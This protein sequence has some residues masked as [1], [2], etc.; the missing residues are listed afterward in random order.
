MLMIEALRQFFR[1][2]VREPTAAHP[3]ILPPKWWEM[4]YEPAWQPPTDA[5]IS[6]LKS[7]SEFLRRRFVDG[8]TEKLRTNVLIRRVRFER[9]DLAL[10]CRY[11]SF[12]ECEFVA[13]RFPGSFFQQVKFSSCTFRLCNFSHVTFERCKF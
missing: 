4:P 7:D 11:S 5:S 12:T 8:S 13:C 6:D 9:C 2:N 1:G 3:P 10:R